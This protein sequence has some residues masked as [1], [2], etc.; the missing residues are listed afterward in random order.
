[1]PAAAPTVPWAI[2]LT[3]TDG[4][5][6]LLAF[7]LDSGRHGI[8]VARADADRLSAHLSELGVPH[9][10]THSGPAGG[11]HIWVRLAAPGAAAE[12]VRQLA[13]A[14]RQHY[15]SLDTAPLSNP[16]TGAVRPPGAPHRHGGYSLPQTSDEALD[17]VLARMEHG[18]TTEVVA[19]LL[20][21][22]P[23]T[24]VPSRD[25]GA[26]TVRIVDDAAGPRLERPRRPLTDRT[27]ALLTTTPSTGTDRSAL[28]HS[29][30]LGMARAGHTLAD[31]RR[32]VDSAP[33][34]ARLRDDAAR[35]RDETV[36]QWRR[37][38][39]AAAQ[40][41]PTTVVERAPIDDELDQVE[42]AVTADPAR[43]ARAGGSSDERILHALI[44]LARTAR[45]RTLDV[46]VR[47]LAEA[48]AVD[49]STASRRLRVLAAEGWV[50][51]IREGAG[52]RASTW[53]LVLPEL[54]A[55][56]GEPAPAPPTG[57]SHALLDH[58]THD[59][60]TH[61]TG[62]GGA[63]AR[64]R[65]ALLNLGKP[66]NSVDSGILHELVALTGYTTGT[67][68]KTIDRLRALRLLPSRTR[69]PRLAR[70]ATIL[71]AAGAA[72]RRAHR[73]LIDRELHRWWTEETEWRGRRGKKRGIRSTA[74]GTIALPISAP[75]RARYGRF[76]TTDTGRADYRAARTIV[77]SMVD[78]P[79][80]YS[81]VAA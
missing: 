13:H 17:A 25:R 37:A 4:R 79:A 55:T 35:G 49:A 62:L 48:A 30:L 7:D 57:T 76:P 78:A 52:T 77:A 42:A 6:R 26:R 34:L 24:A 58:H 51:R 69:A 46:D 21:R 65:W 40:F 32:A 12:D 53:E 81:Q 60:W 45:A 5:Y 59:V 36:R 54:D 16:V 47:R 64:I 31:V 19:W 61:R 10:R 28:A 29:I 2:Y 71:G 3:T 14:L 43:W 67:I 27:R 74:T 38:V 41:A 70:A 15:P 66:I 11:Q 73:H 18:T 56:Q 80:T 8:E 44:V 39:E 68:Q 23:H 33:G 9:L 75:A 72:A 20:A 63:A 22:H 1:M 50:T